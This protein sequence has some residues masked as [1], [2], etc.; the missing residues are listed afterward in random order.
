M[1]N[2]NNGNLQY[3]YD[4]RGLGQIAT[5][6]RFAKIIYIDFVIILATMRSKLSLTK[7]W[8]ITISH[9]SN[10]GSLLQICADNITNT[11]TMPDTFH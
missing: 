4:S 2:N 8:P 6:P 10:L 5:L 11:K 3:S 1:I 7:C 9:D